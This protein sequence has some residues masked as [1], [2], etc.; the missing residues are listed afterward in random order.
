[1]D[2]EVGEEK[3]EAGSVL[4]QE[5]PAEDLRSRGHLEIHTGRWRLEMQQSCN[6][7]CAAKNDRRV[8]SYPDFSIFI[9]I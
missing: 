7:P 9:P 2:G 1:M 3:A 6:A 8:F 5:E 4:D